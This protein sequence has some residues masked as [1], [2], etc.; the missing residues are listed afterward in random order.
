MWGRLFRF[1]GKTEA[2]VETQRATFH[3]VL[4]ELN[5]AMAALPEKPRIILDPGSGEISVEL[6]DTLPD[7][8]V[9]LPPPDKAAA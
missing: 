9:A 3:R 1:T 2:V 6:P 5:D 7:E 8:R 4:G